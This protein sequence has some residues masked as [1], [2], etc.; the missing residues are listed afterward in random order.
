LVGVDEPFPFVAEFDHLKRLQ[1][2]I[3][4]KVARAL[5]VAWADERAEYLYEGRSTTWEAYTRAYIDHYG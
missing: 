1:V 5:G 3:H 4:P 2:P